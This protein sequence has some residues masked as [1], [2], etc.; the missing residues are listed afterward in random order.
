MA[1]SDTRPV[2]LA[3][4]ALKLGDL[5]VAVPA[6]R[7]LRRAFPG[8]EL[9]LAAPGWLAPV[10]PLIGGINRLLETPGLDDPL[11][12]EGPVDIAVNL[13]GNGPESRG[14]LEELSP[15]YRIGHAAPGWAGPEWDDSLHERERW[16]RLVSWH[17][18]PASPDDFRL[19]PPETPAPAE[20]ATIIHVGAAYGSRRWPMERFADVAAV[21]ALKGHR[22]MVTGGPEDTFRAAA[23]ARAAGLPR[24]ACAA[25]VWALDEFA[26]AIAAAR[27]VITADTSAGHLASAY[28]T[29]SVVLFGPATPEQWGPPADGPHIVLTDPLVRHGDPFAELPDPALLAVLPGQV[30]DA[31][32]R[33]ES[34]EHPGRDDDADHRRDDVAV[35]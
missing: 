10:V 24:T 15:T 31:V 11:P 9:I 6:L 14:R 2:L 34:G 13:H 27:V 25:G 3:L 29:P 16:A 32:D 20:G 12:W 21:L 30:L 18:I 23:V 1:Q 17:G 19:C 35:R 8:H 22:V 4:R 5:L 28:G 7:G 33:L 26:A